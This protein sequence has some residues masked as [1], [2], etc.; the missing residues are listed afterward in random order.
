M[1]H[2]HGSRKLIYA[3]VLPMILVMVLLANI[4]MLGMF[5]SNVGITTLGTFSGS[6]PQDG[7]MYFLAPINGPTDWMWWTTDLGHAPWEVLLHLGINIS[8]MVVG[9]AIPRLLI[10]TADSKKMSP[11]RSRCQY[12]HPRYRRTQYPKA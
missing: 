4:Q 10:K 8:F 7:I 12:V 5:L 1:V 9:G 11:A 3:S 2:A 6:T